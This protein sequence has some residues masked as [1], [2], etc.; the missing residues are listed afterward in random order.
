MTD[1]ESLRMDNERVWMVDQMM[2]SLG[3]TKHKVHRSSL[4]PGQFTDRIIYLNDESGDSVSVFFPNEDQSD[5]GLH[6]ATQ[7]KF[8]NKIKSPEWQ[9]VYEFEEEIGSWIEECYRKEQ[10]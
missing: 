10:E 8:N 9:S 2:E 3:F 4:V 1:E 7:A 5:R 6:I